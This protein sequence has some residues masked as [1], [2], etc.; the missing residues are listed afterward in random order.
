[1]GHRT[2]GAKKNDICNKR[3]FDSLSGTK[4]GLRDT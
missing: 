3:D 2:P 1:M 4:A